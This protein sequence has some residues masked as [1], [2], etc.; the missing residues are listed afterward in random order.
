MAS[1]LY[2]E[3]VQRVQQACA[4][5]LAGTANIEQAQAALHAAEQTIVGLEEKWLRALFFAAENKLEEI[6]FTVSDDRQADAA[7]QVVRHVLDAI[8]KPPPA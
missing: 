5:F 3:A 2:P 8:K 6:R 7:D 4:E 1:N